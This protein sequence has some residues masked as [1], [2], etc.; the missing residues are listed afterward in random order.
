MRHNIEI[1][2]ENVLQD[3]SLRNKPSINIPIAIPIYSAAEPQPVEPTNNVAE[4][5]SVHPQPHDAGDGVI[6]E[7]TVSY[8]D[9]ITIFGVIIL[10]ILAVVVII[11]ITGYLNLF[12]AVI[13]VLVFV[14]LFLPHRFTVL[15][16]GTLE[17]TTFGKSK[18][19]Y[20]D[21]SNAYLASDHVGSLV[22]NGQYIGWDTDRIGRVVVK[23]GAGKWHIIT[24]PQD[25]Q[26]FINAGNQVATSP[27]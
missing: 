20:S 10:P 7:T 23:R 26:G 15:A 2:K 25:S 11:L 19:S 12:L 17:V 22:C 24:S 21:I 4:I 16:K 8:Y 14:D 13:I 18:F 27:A 1:E 6:F 5:T 3:L 9:V